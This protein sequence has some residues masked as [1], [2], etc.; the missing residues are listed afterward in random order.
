MVGPVAL[1]KLYEGYELMILIRWG[2]T[3]LLFTW[4]LIRDCFLY[5]IVGEQFSSASYCSSEVSKYSCASRQVCI[6]LL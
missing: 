1:L 3:V 5:E 6:C 2:V 4:A